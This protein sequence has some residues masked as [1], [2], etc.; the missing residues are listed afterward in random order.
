MSPKIIKEL[1]ERHD[2]TPLA[3]AARP[4][5]KNYQSVSTSEPPKV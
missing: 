5:T 2:T 1:Q 3:A 4:N